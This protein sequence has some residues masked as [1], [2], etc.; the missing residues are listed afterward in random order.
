MTKKI[1]C[2]LYTMLMFAATASAQPV[3]TDVVNAGSRITSG[4]PGYGVAQG[5]IFVVTGKGLGP[6]QLQQAAFP[7]PAADGLAGVTVQISVGGTTAN[8]IMVY[9]SGTEV[10]AILPSATPAGTGSVT[11]AYSGQSAT[12]PITV[13]AAAF[14]AFTL[15]QKGDGQAIA[16]NTAGDGST[17]P[18]SVTQPAVPLQTIALNGTGLGAIPSDETQS[19]VTDTPA[20][21]VKVWVGSQQATVVSA[22]RGA[23]CD[24]L[25]SGFP[26]P[27]GVAGW[28]V[29]RF[30]VPAGVSGC[31]VPVA[32]QTGDFISNFASIAVSAGGSGCTEPGG[33]SAG[34]LQNLSATVRIGSV[35]L[36]RSSF[37]I[38]QQ[39]TTVESKSDSGSASFFKYDLSGFQAAASPFNVSAIGSC[40]VYTFKT[41]SGDVPSLNVPATAL[42]AGD[43]INVKGPNGSKQMKRDATTG[44]Y[45][46]DFG[47][48][49]ALPSIPGLPPGLP[50]IPGA[51][52]PFLEAGA[53]SSDNG[54]G[55]ADVGAFVATLTIPQPLTWTNRD[56]IA[57]VTR[58]QGVNVKWSGGDQSGIVNIVGTSSTKVGDATVTGTFLCTERASA[59]QF[60]VPPVVTA[61]LP[62]GTAG[63]LGVQSRTTNRFTAP[64]I[65]IGQISSAVASMKNLAYQ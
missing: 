17:S 27:Q 30:T 55:A 3:I 63:T 45:S 1:E 31:H 52:A 35:Q 54:S 49:V 21:N 60:T 6:D 19:G 7:L 61:S 24:G 2:F 10:A 13:V 53:Y 47:T 20:S 26:I 37:A 41:R 56:Q 25:P 15:D 58:S 14:G 48:S 51:A 43:V 62:A 64:G 46:G 34:D 42:N 38:S 44:S 50:G 16:F 4:L 32:V 59:G 5:A 11:V 22:G 36:S 18:N 40:F 28:D 57:S 23:C 12:A 29:I 65:D 33:F 39:G 8:G 9:V